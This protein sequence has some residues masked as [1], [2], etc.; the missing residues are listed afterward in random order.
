MKSSFP[1]LKLH[2]IGT[3]PS[4]A[5]LGNE[6]FISVVRLPICGQESKCPTAVGRIVLQ[7]TRG[8]MQLNAL[9]NAESPITLGPMASWCAFES[10]LSGASVFFLRAAVRGKLGHVH[11]E[12]LDGLPDRSPPVDAV[13]FSDIRVG[14][15]LIAADNV[16]FRVR[17]CNDQ[18]R[19]AAQLWVLFHLKQHLPPILL[20]HVQIQYIGSH[21]T[22]T[23]RC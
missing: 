7:I 5:A 15:Q 10:C 14:I 23:R 13:W 17:S 21:K 12:L 11:P 4:G 22:E 2:S 9:S 8:I 1:R 3:S 20:R 16:L 19:N 18:Y 6:P